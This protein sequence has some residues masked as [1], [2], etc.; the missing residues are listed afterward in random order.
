MVF[1]DSSRCDGCGACL[2][3]CPVGAISLCDNRA[4]IEE[5]LCEGCAL[6]QSACPQNAILSADM[7]K[8]VAGDETALVPVSHPVQVVTT[9]TRTDVPRLQDLV[10]PAISSVLIWTGREIVPR[11]ASLALAS[12]DRNIQSAEQTIST[13]RM[14][15]RE[16]IQPVQGSGRRRRL[17]RR[18]RGNS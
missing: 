15:P 17:R 6:C 1:I 3:I 7:V 18:R 12:L 11:L 8:P 9:Q 4:F 2:D 16:W 14:R 13:Q 5:N 10:L